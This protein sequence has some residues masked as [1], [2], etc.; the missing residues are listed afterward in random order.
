MSDDILG[1]WRG[2]AEHDPLLS[3]REKHLPALRAR[4]V[5]PRTYTRGALFSALF[6]G[7]P[8]VF[9]DFRVPVRASSLPELIRTGF[10]EGQ[11]AR[12][13]MGPARKRRRL[14][15]PELVARWERRRAIVSVTDLHVRGHRIEEEIDIEP[16]SDFNVLLCGSEGMA[17]QEMMTMV[18]GTRGNVTDSHSDDPDGSN[19]CFVGRK[20]WLAWDTFEGKAAGLEDNSRDT[21]DGAAAFDVEAFLSLRTSRWWTVNAGETLFL[22]G[23]LT[24]RVITLDHY[25]G[26]GSFFVALPSAIQ[27]L[28]RWNAHGPLW[29]LAG[30]KR[31]AGLVD[32]IARTTVLKV[33]ELARSA[34]RQEQWGLSFMRRAVAVWKSRVPAE[35]HDSVLRNEPFAE[36]LRVARQRA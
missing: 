18:V 3:V 10:D 25:L 5:L 21:C 27:T 24:H 4:R 28:A 36:L 22:P 31:K 26:I 13:Q 35:T 11:K 2:A 9:G 1:I 30:E 15:V 14:F 17:E 7:S 23:H 19:H 32:E 12:V 33:K 16:L 8:V 20:L 29:S 34:A 6:D